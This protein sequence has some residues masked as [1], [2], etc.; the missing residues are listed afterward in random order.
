MESSVQENN[1]NNV[2]ARSASIYWKRASLYDDYYYY[3]YWYWYTILTYY[4]PTHITM[5]KNVTSISEIDCISPHRK[6]YFLSAMRVRRASA[7]FNSV[8]PVINKKSARN[9]W[10]HIFPVARILTNSIHSAVNIVFTYSKL[11]V[12]G[13]LC[14]SH[15]LNFCFVRQTIGNSIKWVYAANRFVW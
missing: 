8:C 5:G 4:K 1:R 3:M 10:I 13:N 15:L 2:N 7:Q 11:N 12:I 14:N 6:I 9:K